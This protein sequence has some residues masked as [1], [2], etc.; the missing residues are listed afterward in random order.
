M[1]D[2]FQDSQLKTHDFASEDNQYR[3]LVLD[4]I[5]DYGR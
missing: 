3:T 4:R 1:S 2:E 5:A